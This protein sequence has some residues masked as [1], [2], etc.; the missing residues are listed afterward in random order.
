MN[1]WTKH[2]AEIIW[3][4]GLTDWWP[5]SIKLPG[6][7]P[8]SVSAGWVGAFLPERALHRLDELKHT[9]QRWVRHISTGVHAHRIGLVSE[10]M[11]DEEIGVALAK[12]RGE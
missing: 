9:G 12:A 8:L 11:S 4:H 10:Y 2:E 7:N 3:L 6:D 1:E 5:D